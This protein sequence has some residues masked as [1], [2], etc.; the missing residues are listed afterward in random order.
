MPVKRPGFL[1]EHTQICASSPLTFNI[2]LLEHHEGKEGEN[3]G[4]ARVFVGLKANTLSL[5]D[6]WLAIKASFVSE[7]PLVGQ[8]ILETS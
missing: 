1:F 5:A 8:S 3:W 2:R 4:I 7:T 6:T